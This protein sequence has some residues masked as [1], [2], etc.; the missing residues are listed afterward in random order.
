MGVLF[1][2]FSSE[3][4]YT[5]KRILNYKQV[6]ESVALQV[7]MWPEPSKEM[8]ED[9]N[10]KVRSLQENTSENNQV[11]SP[12]KRAGSRHTASDKNSSAVSLSLL[13]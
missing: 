10:E 8:G 13:Q 6:I 1:F 5:P 11:N 4:T 3:K 9:E 2:F 7:V 12:Y